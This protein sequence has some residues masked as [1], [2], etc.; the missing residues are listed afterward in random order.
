MYDRDDSINQL[1]KKDYWINTLVQLDNYGGEV[2][3]TANLTP[4]VKINSRLTG[5]PKYGMSYL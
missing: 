2:G 5:R 3:I 4:Y 1:E